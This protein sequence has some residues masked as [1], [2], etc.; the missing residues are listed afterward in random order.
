MIVI[1]AITDPKTGS[2]VPSQPIPKDASAIFCNGVNFTV[3]E[4]GDV[5]P[6][7]HQ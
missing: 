5:I 2:L 4:K 1:P 7:E 3:Y 6:P